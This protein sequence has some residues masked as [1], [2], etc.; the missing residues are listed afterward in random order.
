[1]GVD[2]R[3]EFIS[4]NGKELNF[5]TDELSL[6]GDKAVIYYEI[7]NASRYYDASIKMV[8]DDFNDDKVSVTN[9]LNS[10]LIKAQ[11]SSDGVLVTELISPVVGSETVKLKCRIEA[12]PITREEIANDN[13][14]GGCN[15]I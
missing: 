14:E 11:T 12:T 15:N 5:T 1:M 6:V 10:E 2:K 9:V 13:V 4:S 7:T 3:S 8:C